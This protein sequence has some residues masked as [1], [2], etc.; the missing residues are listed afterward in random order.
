MGENEK[1][2]DVWPCPQFIENVNKY[3]AEELWKLAN[4]LIAWNWE[5]TQVLAHGDSMEEVAEELRAAGVDL[6]KVVWDY[7]DD[8]NVSYL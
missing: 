4:K 5:G 3:P 8:P 1:R 6:N 2:N 7:G